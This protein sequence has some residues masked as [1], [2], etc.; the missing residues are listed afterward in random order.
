M[1]VIATISTLRNDIDDTL[2]TLQFA[3]GAK[4]IKNPVECNKVTTKSNIV[5]CLCTELH[6][7]EK[8][9]IALRSSTGFYVNAE[10]YNTILKQTTKKEKELNEKLAQITKME[11]NIKELEEE[12]KYLE[13]NHQELTKSFDITKTRAIMHKTKLLKS[14][15]QAETFKEAVEETQTTIA[16]VIEQNAEL[17]LLIEQTTCHFKILQDRTN[18]VQEKMLH[19]DLLA[20]NVCETLTNTCSSMMQTIQGQKDEISVNIVKTACDIIDTAKTL[21]KENDDLVNKTEIAF[22]EFQKILKSDCNNKMKETVRNILNLFSTD[23]QSCLHSV[24]NKKQNLEEQLQLLRSTLQ[25][26]TEDIK[27]INKEQLEFAEL[28]YNVN[29]KLLELTKTLVAAL[30]E[31][32]ETLTTLQ[33]VLSKNNTAGNKNTCEELSEKLQQ[34]HELKN[35]EEVMNKLINDKIE[36]IQCGIANKGKKI[37]EDASALVELSQRINHQCAETVCAHCLVTIFYLPFNL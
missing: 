17:K 4:T 33:N 34:L 13:A 37:D 20:K 6:K 28:L 12:I 26:N 3:K 10:N 36:E 31:S 21:K 30:T 22:V 23:I 11:D 15:V 7:L 1:A 14:T 8:D 16:P 35:S 25:E 32:S 24:H 29:Q 27:K 5:N 18:L 2:N 9:L 19:N